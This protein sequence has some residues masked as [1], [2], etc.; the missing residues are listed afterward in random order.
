M[1]L[2]DTDDGDEDHDGA[3]A[4][5]KSDAEFLAAGDLDFPNEIRRDDE[6]WNTSG[7][8]QCEGMGSGQVQTH[9]VGQDIEDDGCGF[10]YH[11]SMKVV[12]RRTFD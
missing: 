8:D 10:N 4:E 6:D 9:K 1:D 2:A 3:E 5:E 12:W 11:G 7:S